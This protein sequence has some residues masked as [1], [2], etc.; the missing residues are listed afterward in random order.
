MPAESN[1]IEIFLRVKPVKTPSRLVTVELGEGKAR[2][3]LSD[4][5]YEMDSRFMLPVCCLR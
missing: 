1:N 5:D 3:P 4:S 2:E